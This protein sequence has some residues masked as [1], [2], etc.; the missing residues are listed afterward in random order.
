MTVLATG[1][2]PRL[3]PF[4]LALL[5]LAVPLAGCL[6]GSD[7]VQDGSD[8]GPGAPGDE[9]DSAEDQ[10]E[11][12]TSEPSDPLLDPVPLGLH[13]A[14]DRTLTNA[15]VDEGSVAMEGSWT[16]L[17][18]DFSVTV[19]RSEAFTSPGLIHDEPITLELWLEAQSPTASTGE[20]DLFAW[21]G[22][23]R[24]IHLLE[25]A[26]I[27]EPVMAPG[28]PVLVEMELT[29]DGARPLLVPTGDRI[30]LH[31]VAGNNEERAENLHILTGGETDSRL[32][33]TVSPFVTDPLD[34]LG[35]ATTTTLEGSIQANTQ[36]MNCEIQEGVT[37]ES[38]TL[39]VADDAAY[40]ELN[41]TAADQPGIQDLDMQLLDGEDVVMR[42]ASPD[43]QENILLAGPS[44]QDL[45]GSELTVKVYGCFARDTTYEVTVQQAPST[46]DVD[47]TTT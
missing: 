11:A 24:G 18:S 46:V 1:G 36:F 16:G 33:Y 30:L 47:W 37:H 40:L 42:T 41:L 20:V 32:G 3:F 26:T 31:V 15:T 7:G 25:T 14:P 10:P 39:T 45:Q 27:G 23:T 21:F 12:N 8:A 6:G 38:H 17:A 34:D 35:E 13:L 29:F 28:E 22:S 5:L 19:F 4:A 2:S 9:D 43:A 44:L